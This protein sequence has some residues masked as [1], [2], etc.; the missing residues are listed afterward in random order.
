M[1]TLLATARSSVVFTFQ[2]RT[3]QLATQVRPKWRAPIVKQFRLRTLLIA[4]AIVAVCF[5]FNLCRRLQKGRTSYHSNGDQTRFDIVTRG[6][7]VGIYER[8]RR[9]EVEL[10]GETETGHKIFNMVYYSKD[11]RLGAVLANCLVATALALSFLWLIEQ[12]QSKVNKMLD[13]SGR[14]PEF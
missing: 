2:V 12:I 4:F 1:G 9:S 7:P 13:R 5:Q 8:N 10:V 14:S 3:C 11:L 6:W